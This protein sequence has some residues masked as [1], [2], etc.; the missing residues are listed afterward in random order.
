MDLGRA[1]KF[2]AIGGLATILVLLGT[3][4]L[5]SLVWSNRLSGAEG[6]AMATIL[7]I[8]L[9]ATAVTIIFLFVLL[10]AFIDREFES[11]GL[12]EVEE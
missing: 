1:A 7:I 11:R 2:G 12:D 5:S 4:G 6:K 3:A 8:W 10:G 9:A